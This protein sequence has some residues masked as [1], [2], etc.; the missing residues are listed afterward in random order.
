MIASRR[1]SCTPGRN[2][3]ALDPVIARFEPSGSLVL[4]PQIFPFP[5]RI[6]KQSIPQAVVAP[7]NI[8]KDDGK[9]S[10]SAHKSSVSKFNTFRVVLHH[11][12]A[13][14]SGSSY[15]VSLGLGGSGVLCTSVPLCR[16]PPLASDFSDWIR[17]QHTA[18]VSLS[19]VHQSPFWQ[20][21]QGAD[22]VTLAQ[23]FTMPPCDTFQRLCKARLYSSQFDDA[24]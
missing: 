1:L 17:I 5:S 24:I 8:R 11:R 12:L 10:R 3:P 6:G 16:Y 9:E 4:I 22:F 14:K 23:T 15:P 20:I 19:I 7:M 21:G 13:S 2:I 18:P